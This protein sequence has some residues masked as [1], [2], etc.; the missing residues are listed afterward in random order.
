MYTDK[1]KEVHWILWDSLYEQVLFQHIYDVAG[2]INYKDNKF[3]RLINTYK[4]KP[5]ETQTY[6]KCIL[7]KYKNKTCSKC[8]LFIL[9][10]NNFACYKSSELYVKAQN[11]DLE[12]IITIRDIFF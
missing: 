5:T 2:F 4:L 10:H 3:H 9:N 7:C 11:S 1:E 8:P 6:T 12:A